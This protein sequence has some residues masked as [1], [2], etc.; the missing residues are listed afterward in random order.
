MYVEVLESRTSQA[1]V[2]QP[3]VG[4]LQRSA[5]ADDGGRGILRPIAQEGAVAPL[6]ADSGNQVGRFNRTVDLDPERRAAFRLRQ[7]F[8]RRL[9]KEAEDEL[10]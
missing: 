2:Q 8:K 10:C 9:L 5:E 3:R 6:E 4:G 7:E 1:Q